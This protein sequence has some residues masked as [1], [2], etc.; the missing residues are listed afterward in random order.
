MKKLLCCYECGT[1]DLAWEIEVNEF[2]KQIYEPDEF[3][4][5]C[6]DHAI[7]QN[8]DCITR[9]NIY[10]EAIPKSEFAKEVA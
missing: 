9:D 7:C 10:T 1:D 6:P 5:S 8:S 3:G 4:S 2:G